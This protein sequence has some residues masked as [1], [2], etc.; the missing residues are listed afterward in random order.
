M[1]NNVNKLEQTINRFSISRPQLEQ[2]LSQKLDFE[3]EALTYQVSGTRDEME[4]T[5]TANIRHKLEYQSD[6]IEA[7]T[8]K[9]HPSKTQTHL[10]STKSNFFQRKTMM[11]CSR[12]NQ[13]RHY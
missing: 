8:T 12:K 2:K 7:P 6:A 4:K 5:T 3:F 11:V 1:E 13:E 10:S 9:L